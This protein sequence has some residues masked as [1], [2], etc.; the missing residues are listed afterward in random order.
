MLMTGKED[1]NIFAVAVQPKSII[2]GESLSL[3]VREGV[4]RLTD[5]FA[6]VLA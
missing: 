5:I 4:G 3:E 6:E 2:F 1:L